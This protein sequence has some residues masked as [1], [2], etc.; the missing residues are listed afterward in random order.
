M[1]ECGHAER[2]GRNH[3]RRAR[4]AS[5]AE[6]GQRPQP[7]YYAC[8]ADDGSQ[9][10]EACAGLVQRASGEARQ[11]QGVQGVALLWDEGH[12]YA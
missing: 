10:E 1:Q 8:T 12:F 9:G 6:N 4:V 3:R 11:G 5:H 7:L 2:P